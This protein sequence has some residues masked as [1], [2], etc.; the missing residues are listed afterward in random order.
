MELIKKVIPIIEKVGV[1]IREHAGKV[2]LDDIEHKT[3]NNMVSYVDKTA[4]KM[5]VENLR[6]IIPEAGFLTEEETV[7]NEEKEWTWIID[8]LDGTT[9]FLHGIPMFSISVA[10]LHNNEIQYGWVYDIMHS[11]MFYAQLNTGAFLNG[12]PI[13]ISGQEDFGQALMVTG[14]PYESPEK[15]KKYM[16]V[17]FELMMNTRGVRRMGSAAL[18]LVYVACGRFDGYYE[19]GLNAWDVAAGSLILKEAGGKVSDFKNGNDFV[20]GR[21]IVATNGKIHERLL[22]IIKEK[23]LEE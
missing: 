20:F 3:L 23:F 17:F 6:P 5:L 11:D 13:R 7:S 1:F 21:E 9:N 2:A 14:F 8:P 10:L 18:D 19:F 22:E 16:E 4:E 12:N 15:I